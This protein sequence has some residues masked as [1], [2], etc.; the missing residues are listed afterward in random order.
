MSMEGINELLKPKDGRNFHLEFHE[1]LSVWS[2]SPVP[3]LI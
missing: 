2:D 1:K 3:V